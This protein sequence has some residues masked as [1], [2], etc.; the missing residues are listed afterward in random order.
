[1]VHSAFIFVAS[2]LLSATM[3]VADIRD[4]VEALF[5][6]DVAEFDFARAK[7]EADRLIEPSTD[8]KAELAR[9]DEMVEVI[10]AML[11]ANASSWDKVQTLRQFIYVAGP[12]NEGRAFSYDHDDP[13]GSD[14]RNKLLTDYIAD[15]RGN[16]VTMPFLFIALGQRLGLE[17]TPAM[18]P[19]HVLVKFTDDQG[20]TYNLE[21]TSGGGP[22]RDQHYRNLFPI[23]DEA[24]AN[25]IFLAPLTNEQSVSLIGAVIVEHLT[26][27]ERYQD[28]IDVADILLDHY[29]AFAYMMV[30]RGTAAY[31]LLRNEF[32]EH[33]QAPRDVPREKRP[34]LAYLQ[35]V[36]QQSFDR[37]E[38]LGWRPY[39]P[40]DL[41]S[42]N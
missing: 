29:P 41:K 8:V 34:Q 11:P 33:Y 16:C 22:A 23:T 5:R 42:R 7:F 9:L 27:Q 26:T 19:I 21:T 39:N 3:A 12:W 14:V 32:F 37:A 4:D 2:L 31:Y 18:A 20:K 30:K 13:Y 40:S 36:N 6:R 15:R 35:T 17:L 28:A 24:L 25:G 38:A 1:M 10:E